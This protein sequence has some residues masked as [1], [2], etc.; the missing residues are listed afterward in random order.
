MLKPSWAI[1]KDYRSSKLGRYLAT[2]WLLRHNVAGFGKVGGA[3][4]AMGLFV[5]LACALPTAVSPAPPTP[6]PVLTQPPTRHASP[7]EK[8]FAPLQAE[9][10]APYAQPALFPIRNEITFTPRLPLYAPLEPAVRKAL[11][12]AQIAINPA[13]DG[14]LAWQAAAER[15]EPVLVDGAWVAVA[16]LA[17]QERAWREVQA[18][19]LPPLLAEQT[20][21]MLAQTAVDWER[22]VAEEPPHP[23]AE[24]AWRNLAYF[25]VAA[26]LLNADFVPPTAV[27]DVVASEVALAQQG[28]TFVSPLL[29]A[30]ANYEPLAQ[31]HTPAERALRWYQQMGLSAAEPVQVAQVRL[32]RPL[33]SPAWQ[34]L[35][36]VLAYRYGAPAE[37]DVFYFLPPYQS[38]ARPLTQ[39]L[40]YNRVGAWQGAGAWPRSAGETAVGTVR[41][42]GLPLD[43]AVVAGSAE[44]ERRWLAAGEGDFA[45]LTNQLD[46]L[47]AE[48]GGD[49]AV[50]QQTQTWRGAWLH[51]LRP[52]VT[53]SAP[54]TTPFLQSEAWQEA[55]L[56][57]WLAAWSF[58]DGVPPT[59]EMGEPIVAAETTIYLAPQ[60]ILYGRLAAHTRQ[61]LVGW[62]RAGMLSESV[63]AELGAWEALLRE[64][65]TMAW[66]IGA[67]QAVT[68]KQ[69][70]QLRGLPNQLAAVIGDPASWGRWYSWDEGTGRGVW[71]SL[72]PQ[73]VYVS[74]VWQGEQVV[75]TGVKW[76]VDTAVASENTPDR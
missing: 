21:A 63:A 35:Y 47:R 46:G 34:Q 36:D 39:A 45:G 38:L 41:L 6:P 53:P 4:G 74:A 71:V 26:A 40:T 13:E 3:W 50:A 61:L 7:N 1:I 56:A 68:A 65:E 15:G 72:S 24:A 20:S 48:F 73:V 9:G 64:L 49:T 18:A 17:V 75:A 11:L 51:N 25:S 59:A 42:Y 52:L 23:D 19:Y 67:G 54:L 5:L 33:I 28:G 2:R 14:W 12:A 31:A 60:P 37:S 76:Q 32:A 70:A 69:E 44:A 8:P 29:G 27:R 62:H 30:V 58:G 16:T 43:A 55:M 66:Q 22:L 10:F 57:G